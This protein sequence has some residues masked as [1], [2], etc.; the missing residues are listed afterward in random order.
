MYIPYEKIGNFLNLILKNE[1]LKSFFYDKKIEQNINYIEKNKKNVLKKINKKLHKNEPVK[2]VFYVYDETKWKCQTVYDMFENDSRFEPLILVT[3]SAAKNSDNPTYQTIDDVKKAYKFFKDKNL[4]AEFAYDVKKDKFIPFEKFEPDIIFYQ[5][6]WYVERTQGPVVCSKF[7]FTAY[8]PYYFPMEIEGVDN[9]I[10]YYLRFHKYVERYYALDSFIEN[11]LKN[12][13]DNKGVNVKAVGYPNLDYFIEN[14]VN[15]DY[16]IYSPHWTVGGLGHN[17]G[18]FEWSGLYMLEYAKQHPEIKWVFKPHPLLRKSLSD[19]SI[20]TE[21]EVENYYNEWDKIGIRYEGGDYLEWFLK[22]KMM[23]TDSC[24]FLGE[25]FVTE[26]PLILLMS[27]KSPF[28]SLNH[29]ILKTY[30]CAH[31]LDELKHFLEILPNDD[32][33]KETR[34][35][36]LNESGLKNNKASKKIFDD[37]I[38]IIGAKNVK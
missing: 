24:S 23:I 11:K 37:I 38:E 35:Q 22:S 33:M 34:L 19:T 25:Y 21:Q 31:N 29:H 15:G 1:S 14:N 30:Y 5:H 32:Y 12:K 28:R 20:M 26:K 8:V 17:Y 18:T 4:K 9:K 36:A 2:V 13:M 16:V 6:P 7:A 3:K 10:D 27:D